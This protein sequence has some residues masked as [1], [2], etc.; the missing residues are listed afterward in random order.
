MKCWELPGSPKTP[1]KFHSSGNSTQ[2][3]SGESIITYKD[4]RFVVFVPVGAVQVEPVSSGRGR[5]KQQQRGSR[6]R[7]V[8]LHRVA[9][10]PAP[11]LPVEGERI[12]GSMKRDDTTHSQS[13]FDLPD[14][15]DDK[16]ECIYSRQYFVGTS[17]YDSL[18]ERNLNELIQYQDESA[19]CQMDSRERWNASMAVEAVQASIRRWAGTDGEDGGFRC[20]ELMAK[21]NGCDAGKTATIIPVSSSKPIPRRMSIHSRRRM[22]H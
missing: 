4:L 3:N 6:M 21:A 2:L 11:Y 5:P 18:L 17:E 9:G 19:Y 8:K 16:E 13:T 12:R 20:M 14:G 10:C 15:D 7:F 22:M 1:G